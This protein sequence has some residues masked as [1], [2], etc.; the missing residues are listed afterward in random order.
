MEKKSPPPAAISNAEH[1]WSDI[2]A[3]ACRE[4]A[5]QGKTKPPSERGWERALGRRGVSRSPAGGE[6]EEETLWIF[7]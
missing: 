7:P 1:R 6:N 2:A 5:S 3:A 4:V